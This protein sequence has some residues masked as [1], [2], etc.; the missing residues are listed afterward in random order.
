VNP[1]WWRLSRPGWLAGAAATGAAIALAGP[2]AGAAA[3]HAVN[4][5]L[6]TAVAAA[7]RD[8]AAEV[9]D[10]APRRRARRRL[11]PVGCAVLAAAATWPAATALLAARAPG[12]PWRG[13]AV[14][15]AAMVAVACAAGVRC[16]DAEP[17]LAGAG[18]LAVV[19][20]LD[21]G[22]PGGSWLTGEPGPRW[23]R[24]REAWVLIGL[25]AAVVV[26]AGVR[27]PAGR[28]RPRRKATTQFS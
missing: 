2:P 22:I 12:L 13:L 10:A 25:A 18:V 1:Y 7:L 6:A 17:G 3:G 28:A 16:A 23:D 14:E 20:L 15:A 5:A 9:L 19:V 27:D 4:I 8:P 21:Q 11:A 24:G 26:L